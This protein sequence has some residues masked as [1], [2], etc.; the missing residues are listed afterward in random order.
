MI[1]A[2]AVNGGFEAF[3]A[4]MVLNHCRVLKVEKL[5]RGVSIVSVVFFMLWGMWNLYYYPSLAQ[6][7]SFY[8]GMLVVLSN[9]F[10]VGMLLG[11]RR[12]EAIAIRID[13]QTS[14][15]SEKN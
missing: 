1:S 2:D 14:A 9:I 11:Y 5:V 7:L 10:Y 4:V 15:G 13:N 6:P 3:A 12:Q 8:G